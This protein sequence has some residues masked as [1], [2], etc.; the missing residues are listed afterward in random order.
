VI[1]ITYLAVTP[2]QGVP[3]TLAFPHQDDDIRLK[4]SPLAEVVCQ[5][6]FP[7]ILSIPERTPVA[8][9][10]RIRKRFPE[11]EVEE[12]IMFRVDV[13]S[14]G[15]SVPAIPQQSATRT[16]KFSSRK[17]ATVATLAI[18]FFALS[19]SRYIVWE[20]FANDLR[21][22]TDAARGIYDPSHATR[23]GLRYINH[24]VPANLGLESVGAV[25]DLLQ[26]ELTTLFRT[27][28]WDEPS[29]ASVQLVL[30]DEEVGGRLGFRMGKRIDNLQ[31]SLLLDFDYFEENEEGLP[32]EELVERCDR[33]H[34]VIYN[35]FRWSIAADGLDVFEPVPKLE[36][37]E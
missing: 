19:T 5:V 27:S 10:D 16:Y 23:I 34:R 6:R 2:D 33:Y 26:P 8:F 20:E 9:Q 3:M 32:L 12:G 4:R 14:G 29:E 24:L 35:A 30:N 7:P 18:D 28:V 15:L 13:A 36:T 17:R 22:L 37:A 11:Y 21:L 31:P 25:I 1:Q